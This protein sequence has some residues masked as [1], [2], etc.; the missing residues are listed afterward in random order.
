M[1]II[2]R[3]KNK[4]KI[5]FENTFQNQRPNRRVFQNHHKQ[6]ICVFWKWSDVCFLNNIMM[7]LIITTEH[8]STSRQKIFLFFPHFIWFQVELSRR[9]LWFIKQFFPFENFPPIFCIRY[10]YGISR[11]KRKKHLFYFK[12]ISQVIICYF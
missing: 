4:N 6:E 7:M 1:R 8:T 5:H 12:L 2:T 10:V 11:R 3:N 9:M